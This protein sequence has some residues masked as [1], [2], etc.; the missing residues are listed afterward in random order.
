VRSVSIYPIVLS[1]GLAHIKSSSDPCVDK[2]SLSI[3]TPLYVG[4]KRGEWRFNLQNLK[5]RLIRGIMNK[6]W[7]DLNA[8]L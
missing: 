3:I 1:K 8:Y 7:R 6:I 4:L 2:A 5:I